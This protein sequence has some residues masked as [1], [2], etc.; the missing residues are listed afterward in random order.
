MSVA[1][2]YPKRTIVTPKSVLI[3]IHSASNW[4]SLFDYDRDLVVTVDGSRL[5]LGKMEGNPNPSL[6][7]KSS[8]FFEL[9][10]Q[11]IPY[12]D[13]ARIAKAKKAKLQVGKQTF[14][15]TEK[16]LLSL[17]DFLELMEQEGQEFRQ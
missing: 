7:K 14:D 11:S 8:K 13:Y 10:R 6:S 12:E 2:E 17:S 4:Q 3:V 9:L 15:L 16:Q 1:F 5:P